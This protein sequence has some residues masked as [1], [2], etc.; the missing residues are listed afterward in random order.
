[1]IRR[2]PLKRSPAPARRAP[3]NRK[4]AGERRVSVD[5]SREYLVFRLFGFQCEVS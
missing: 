4:R 3:V 5:R 1:M 2:T